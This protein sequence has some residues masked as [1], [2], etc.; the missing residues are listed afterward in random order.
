MHPNLIFVPYR[1]SE[2]IALIILRVFAML[3]ILLMFVIY[4]AVLILDFSDDYPILKSHL[5]SVDSLPIPGISG[6]LLYNRAKTESAEECNKY[7]YQPRY[8]QS[9]NSYVGYFNS[10][11]NISFKQNVTDPQVFHAV[12]FSTLI[13]PK[14]L[15]NDSALIMTV[16]AFDPELDPYREPL[17]NLDDFQANHVSNWINAIIGMNSFPITNG[18][19]TMFSFT[20]TIREFI[21]P[22]FFES[23]GLQT[24]L[25]REPY[26]TS[27]VVT[28]G[29]S[30]SDKVLDS[31]QLLG[32]ITVKPKHFIETTETE[33]R[34]ISILSCIPLLGGA[35]VVGAFIYAWIFGTD[36]VRPWGCA[37]KYCCCLSKSIKR[38]LRD[39]LE[40][41][42]LI[43]PKNH[44]PLS[45]ASSM[46]SHKDP[47]I[48]NLS[49]RV[50]ELEQQN[51]ALQF[52]LRE[53]VVDSAYFKNLKILD[54]SSI[55]SSRVAPR[56]DKKDETRDWQFISQQIDFSD[57]GKRQSLS[58]PLSILNA[59]KLNERV[60]AHQTKSLPVVIKSP[61]SDEEE[62]V[63]ENFFAE[64]N[65]A[66][67]QAQLEAI[68][69]IDQEFVHV[70]EK[71]LLKDQEVKKLDEPQQVDEIVDVAQDV[72]IRIE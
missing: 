32:K 22:G 66:N 19:I 5:N 3:V 25:L 34:L 48:S 63:I 60:P 62:D 45:R 21:Q 16:S 29:I 67:Q 40:V 10:M 26:L 36:M 41:L 44:Q 11:H 8:I 20:R 57:D 15:K 47:L 50:H 17:Y 68:K 27:T 56:S 43:D 4:T 23:L 53:Y 12:E 33:H 72:L 13:D 6:I 38:H 70:E 14:N 61:S 1:R 37:Q 69:K 59:D 2:P 64:I 39:S 7:I 30:S 54:Q 35:W 71:N 31:L 52:V 42:P 55:R 65:R 28:T 49:I 46:R 58:A 51:T 24:P 18:Q 9:M